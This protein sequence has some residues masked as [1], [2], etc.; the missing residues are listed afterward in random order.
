MKPIRLPPS[1]DI[2]LFLRI[3]GALLG[4]MFL[5]G[6]TWAARDGSYQN[7][8]A[9]FSAAA[10]FVC[11]VLP[12]RPSL[13]ALIVLSISSAKSKGPGSDVSP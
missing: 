13:V 6:A 10:M 11:V 12:G 9:L 4:L 8:T 7:I 2:D 3:L 1:Q 5:M